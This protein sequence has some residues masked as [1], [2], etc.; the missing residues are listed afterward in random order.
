VITRGGKS[1]NAGVKAMLEEF[2]IAS[3]T[4][5]GYLQF[6]D[7][8]PLD[9]DLPIESFRVQVSDDHLSAS[10]KVD[11][12]YVPSHPAKLFADMA[13]KWSGW[14]GELVWE[15]LEGEFQLRCTHDGLGHIAIRVELRSGPM[16][17]DWQVMAT[18]MT[19]AGQLETIAQ[20]AAVFFGQA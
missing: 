14:P 10:G 15:S 2:R 1:K 19:E 6:A 18:V 5:G 3:T 9:P 17:D 8:V 20:Q 16:H 13:A 11:A 4:G 7:R 12:G